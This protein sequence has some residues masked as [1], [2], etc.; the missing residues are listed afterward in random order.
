M[1]PEVVHHFFWGFLT[2]LP[3]DLS[4]RLNMKHSPGAGLVDWWP[5]GLLFSFGPY[6]ICKFPQK[7]NETKQ[8]NTFPSSLENG[9]KSAIVWL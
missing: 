5:F 2:P 4:Q 9:P 7:E 1:F 8:K 6:S 3:S